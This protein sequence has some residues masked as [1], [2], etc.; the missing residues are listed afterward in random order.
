MTGL[1]ENL[2]VDELRSTPYVELRK[3]QRESKAWLK[4]NGGCTIAKASDEDIDKLCTH[5]KIER[6]L[7]RRAKEGY[8]T[9]RRRK[10][11]V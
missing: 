6:E 4:A 7:V 3:L 11:S 5:Y 2:S 9:K 10:G 8:G 1:S